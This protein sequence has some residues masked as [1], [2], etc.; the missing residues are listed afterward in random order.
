MWLYVR[1]VLLLLLLL[2]PQIYTPRFKPV[3]VPLPLP[4]H[5]KLAMKGAGKF[6]KAVAKAVIENSGTDFVSEEEEVEAPAAEPMQPVPVPSAPA[7]TVFVP[8]PVPMPVPVS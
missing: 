3:M 7:D 2:L 5:P 1:H 6:I 4:V 8:T